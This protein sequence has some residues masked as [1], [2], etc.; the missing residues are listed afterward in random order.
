[1]LCGTLSDDRVAD[2]RRG[3]DPTASQRQAS[4]LLKTPV[5]DESCGLWEHAVSSSLLASLS[6]VFWKHSDQ[7]VLEFHKGL[8]VIKAVETDK[9]AMFN[10]T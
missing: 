9:N 7:P 6:S 1:M 2:G 10:S 4:T 5:E 8:E 3:E